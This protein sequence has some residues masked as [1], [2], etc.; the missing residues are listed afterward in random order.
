MESYSLV[1]SS[2]EEALNKARLLYGDSMRIQQRRDFTTRGFLGLFGRKHRCEL[3][4]Y[5]V[6]DSPKTASKDDADSI[7]PVPNQNYISQP[8][9]EGAGYTQ[10]FEDNDKQK[11]QL[12]PKKSSGLGQLLHDE[13]N[14]LIDGLLDKAR[15]VLS[16]ND[17]S[18]TY[19]GNFIAEIKKQL[20]SALP[21]LPSPENFEILLLDNIV[22]SFESDHS[23]QLYPPKYF[24][25][26]GP[27]G[28][29][30]TATASK[31]GNLFASGLGKSA[32]VVQLVPS[33]AE[34]PTNEISMDANGVFHSFFK[35]GDSFT[36]RE[37][38]EEKDIFIIDSFSF[39][40]NEEA[41]KKELLEFLLRLP[42]GD[43]KYFLVMEASMKEKDLSKVF[44]SYEKIVFQSI[45]LTKCDE[46]ETIG[47]VISVC[48]QYGMPLLFITDG[49]DLMSNIHFASSFAILSK[50]RGFDMDINAL[51][52]TN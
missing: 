32:E 17:F 51:A 11:E 24:V 6:T 45:V 34:L 41:M 13:N 18:E 42:K 21:D 47:N 2:Y 4:V 40:S 48:N 14:K 27:S 10:Y 26:C 15:K 7:Q 9:D 16:E 25:L 38:K 46:S 39:S 1:C 19:S 37:E 29:G 8:S 12:D 31:I 23:A 43:T 50:L 3:T 35:C 49:R 20:T 30:K 28:V 36:K 5:L 33:S 44:S 22:S 52:Q